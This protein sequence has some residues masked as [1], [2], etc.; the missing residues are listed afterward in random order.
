MCHTRKQELSRNNL[1]GGRRSGFPESSES[2]FLEIIDK[3]G[4]L[5]VFERRSLVRVSPLAPNPQACEHCLSVLQKNTARAAEHVGEQCHSPELKLV[6][7]DGRD[8][9][10]ADSAMN[11][12]TCFSVDPT[13]VLGRFRLGPFLRLSAGLRAIV[14]SDFF[15]KTRAFTCFE[16]LHESCMT[17]SSRRSFTVS[18]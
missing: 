10:N 13:P 9:R 5:N 18:R 15:T 11:R 14:N 12:S 1:D 7:P 4:A 17:A 2:I 16:L 3:R 6:R 8:L